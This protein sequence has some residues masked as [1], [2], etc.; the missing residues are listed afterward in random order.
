MRASPSEIAETGSA[1]SAP[2]AMMAS[3]FGCVLTASANMASGLNPNRHSTIKDIRVAPARRR[4]ALMI[5]T[6]VV[7]FMPP[8][9]T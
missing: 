9:A 8:N 3:P 2:G 6:Q 7:A 1:T 4:H 5:C